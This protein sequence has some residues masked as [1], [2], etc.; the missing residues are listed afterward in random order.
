MMIQATP[1]P[2]DL[3]LADVTV[4]IVTYNSAHCVPVLARDLAQFPHLMV[5]DNASND[6]T[7]EAVRHHL[8]RATILAHANNLGFGAANNRALDQVHTRFAFLLNPDCQIT[9]QAVISMLEVFTS[10]PQAAVVAPQLIGTRGA[11]ELNYRWPSVFWPPKTGAAEAICCVGHVCGAAVLIQREVGKD[12]ARFDEDFF[13]YYEDDDLCLRLFDAK[14]SILLAPHVK[15]VHSSRGSVRGKHPLQA[16]Y[17][18]GYHHA[19][20]KILFMRKHGNADKAK[21]LHR[22]T[23]ILA[24]LSLP[25]RMLLPVPKHVARHWGRIRGLLAMR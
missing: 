2:G 24:C 13:L 17:G 6:E 1:P 19:Q 11:L 12:V 8:P 9:A 5:S 4:I 3:A 16:E 21:R 7:V 23:L 20:S 22:R 10:Y 25:L 18:R 15:L 14:K